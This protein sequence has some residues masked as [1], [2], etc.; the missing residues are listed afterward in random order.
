MPLVH[1]ENITDHCR[2]MVWELTE[3]EEVLRDL[4]PQTANTSELLLVSHP[5]KVR[6]WLAGRVVISTLVQEAGLRFEGIWKDEHGKPFL[7]DSTY[8]ISLTHTLNYVAAVIHPT[9][10]IGI[11][12][13]K[14]DPKLIRTA[15]KYLTEPEIEQTNTQLERYCQY[16]CAKEA[17]Y[18]LNGR[19]KVSFRDDIRIHAFG[20]TSDLTL[21]ELHDQGRVVTA[22]LF[23]RWFGDYCLVVAV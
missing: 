15:P 10:P 13:E 8:Y 11:D 14:K 23:D 9:Q 16:W 21:G 3:P 18:K 19:K 4:L 6:E 20:D 22:R 12:M 2:L 1:S 7:V 5:Q 17:I